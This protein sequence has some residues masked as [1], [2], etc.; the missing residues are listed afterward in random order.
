[1]GLTER[2][3]FEDEE[4]ELT[5]RQ[6]QDAVEERETARIDIPGTSTIK[7]KRQIPMTA[8]RCI[9]CGAWECPDFNHELYDAVIIGETAGLCKSCNNGI[10]K[11]ILWV[12]EHMNDSN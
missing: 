8:T 11:A 3:W 6:L 4:P 7:M 10:K 2:H 9:V 1:M 5:E 12:E